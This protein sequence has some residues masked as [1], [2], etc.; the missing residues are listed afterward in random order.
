[1]T[2]VLYNGEEND[3]GV[4]SVYRRRLLDWYGFCFSISLWNVFEIALCDFVVFSLVQTVLWTFD[5]YY[6]YLSHLNYM[7]HSCI[8]IYPRV[9]F[10][11]LG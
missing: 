4:G 6:A 8:L 11:R 1:M 5:V 3:A 9:S 2:V 10:S 7:K